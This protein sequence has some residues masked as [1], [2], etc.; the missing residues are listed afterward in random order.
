MN[1]YQLH[2]NPRANAIL[3][4]DSHIKQLPTSMVNAML[5]VAWN[6]GKRDL[7]GV[8][9]DADKLLSD[10]LSYSS[11]N[12]SQAYQLT[13][14]VCAEHKHRFDKPHESADMLKQLGQLDFQNI[15]EMGVTPFPSN[16]VEEVPAMTRDHIDRARISFSVQDATGQEWTNRNKPEWVTEMAKKHNAWI[17]RME[18]KEHARKELEKM[19]LEK[20][21]ARQKEVEK[22][23]EETLDRLFPARKKRKEREAEEA[24]KSSKKS[25]SKSK[26]KSKNKKS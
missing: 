4:P 19:R 26:S 7:P 16:L 21:K 3:L 24:K 1:F 25:S 20:A 10:W 5:N 2:T 15:P 23:R 14:A 11:N 6:Q 12:W 9:D 17:K 8:P 18:E 13:L 22:E